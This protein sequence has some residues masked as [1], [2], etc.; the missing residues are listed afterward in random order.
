MDK[1]FSLRFLPSLPLASAIITLLFSQIAN[2][3]YLQNIEET[4]VDGKNLL[5]AR[6]SEGLDTSVSIGEFFSVYQLEQDRNFPLVLT[7]D[8]SWELQPAEEGSTKQNIVCYASTQPNTSYQVTVSDRLRSTSNELLD[9]SYEF[10]IKTRH[11]QPVASF[12]G[13]G[14]ILIPEMSEGI[15]IV[16]VNVSE[17]KLD[18]Y[19]LDR[20]YVDDNIN[21]IV[22]GSTYRIGRDLENQSEPVYSAQYSTDAPVNTRV[23]RV[24]PIADIDEIKPLGIYLVAMSRPGNYQQIEY[25]YFSVSDLGVHARFYQD[26]IHFHVSS[27]TDATAIYDAQIRIYEND[28]SLIRRISTDSSGQALFRPGREEPGYILVSKGDQQSFMSIQQPSLDLSE[29]DVGGRPYQEQEIF[30]YSTRDLYRPGESISISGLLRDADG[31]I[32]PPVALEAEVI[33]PGNQRQESLEVTAGPLGYYQFDFAISSSARTGDWELRVHK[34]DD[35]Y[36]SYKFKVEEFLPERMELFADP[37]GDAR[38]LRPDEPFYLPI[39]GNY[40]YGAPAS[41][42]QLAAQIKSAQWRQP[43]SDE[44]SVKQLQAAFPDEL[45]DDNIISYQRFFFGDETDNAGLVSYKLNN[46]RLDAEGLINLA[47]QNRW[48]QSNSPMQITSTLSLQE[49]GGRPVTRLHRQ[50]VWPN[51]SM[52]GIAPLFT[53]ENLTAYSDA[54]FDLV[55][56]TEHFEN[57]GGTDIEVRLIRENERYFWQYTSGRGWHYEW[58]NSEYLEQSLTVDIDESSTASVSL[59]VTW[60]KYRL[61]AIDPV[62]GAKT[63]LR[64]TADYHWYWRWRNAQDQSSSIRPD[65]VVLAWDKQ[66][67]QEGDQAKLNIV[68]PF[69]GEHVVLVESSELLWAERISSQEN[70]TQI[71]IPISANWNRHDIYVSVIS[72]RPAHQADL[73]TP[74]RALGIIHL[75]LDRDS[76]ELDV[77]FDPQ[78]IISEGVSQEL[79]RRA[80]PGTNYQVALSVKNADGSIPEEAHVTLAAVDVGVLN[81]T[82]FDTPDAHQWFFEPRRFS[83]DSRDIYNEIIELTDA[84]TARLQFGGDALSQS[85]K[86]ADPEVKI[87]Q[88]FNEPVSINSLGKAEFD[89]ALPD[90]NGRMRLMAMVFTEDSYG[91]VEDD[92]QIAAPLVAEIAMPKFLAQRDKTEFAIDLTNMTESP[93]SVLPILEAANLISLQ[94]IN[95]ISQSNADPVLLDAGQRITLRYE[96]EAGVEIGVA[97]LLLDIQSPDIEDFQRNWALTVRAAY[98]QETRQQSLLLGTQQPD[99]WLNTE[100]LDGLIE[101]T[102]EMSLVLN[103]NFSLQIQNQVGALFQYPYGCLEQT[104]SRLYPWIWLSDKTQGL[105]GV[106]EETL[107]KQDENIRRG[108]QRLST[109][110]KNHGGFGYWSVTSA[111]SQWVTVFVAEVLYNLHQQGLISDLDMLESANRRLQAYLDRPVITNRYTHNI[112]HYQLA[113][114]AYAAYVLAKQGQTNLSKVRTLALEQLE[115]ADSPL[116][117][118]HLGLAHYIFGDRRTADTLFDKAF[119]TTRAEGYLGDYGSSYRDQAAILALLAEHDLREEDR[120]NIGLKLS[121]DIQRKR[122][123]STQER[124]YLLRAAIAMEEYASSNQIAVDLYTSAMSTDSSGAS[125][126]T[127]G[128]FDKHLQVSGETSIAI[129]LDSL[130]SGIKLSMTDDSW[131]QGQLSVTGYPDIDPTQPETLIEVGEFEPSPFFVERYYYDDQGNPMQLT[132]IAQGDLVITH[133]RI[134]SAE[135]YQDALV[136]DLLPAG[137]ELENQNLKHAI[138]LDDIEVDGQSLEYWSNNNDIVFQE[139]RD[140]RFVAAVDLGYR[141]RSTNL[142]Y[143]A[144]AVAPGEYSV[145]PTLVEDMYRPEIRT[146]GDSQP[147]LIV[148]D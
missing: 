139:Y 146:L 111:E 113:Y 144:R 100:L 143:L 34:P 89:L 59:P 93:I 137:L 103:N 148:T 13:N 10:N 40:L 69:A 119:A 44:T 41:G 94:P 98:P 51:N 31:N 79:T 11:L 26:E 87:H 28:D 132:E 58:A 6:F 9:D 23:E 116:P 122:Y 112:D 82:D 81:I 25:K 133:I 84:D 114:R 145:P 120:V 147:Q 136:V 27:L 8:H 30:L 72:L 141:W 62:S 1:F 42:N 96:V 48:G 104:S 63:T 5:C 47:I 32:Q 124:A 90:F 106:D 131:L 39:E 68:A 110:Q 117:L 49:S 61:E 3:F 37:E 46:Q 99:L 57:M 142:F 76:R 17:V 101:E 126:N 115:D 78:I 15:P 33:A 65:R 130:K 102:V 71:T 7:D 14:S 134:D 80:E 107:I 54:E 118:V 53:T 18:F 19:R 67:Y 43:F 95:Y 52:L 83:T 50:L 55:R 91:M 2:A 29:F 20:K 66:N 70:G 125:I 73:V 105:L 77:A 75:P 86:K 140:D 127:E 85:D 97:Q 12:D 56:L 60:G 109:M 21:A 128:V 16:A 123:L 4:H 22:R 74:N 88:I 92:L 108:L 45:S 36:Q 129:D 24:V 38:V 121:E 64:F 138:K 135:R 35:R